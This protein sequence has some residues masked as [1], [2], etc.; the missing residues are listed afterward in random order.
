MVSGL[1][2]AFAVGSSSGETGGGQGSSNT[3]QYLTVAIAFPLVL[4]FFQAIAI[5][6]VAEAAGTS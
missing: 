4:G 3:A 6:P 5:G 2:Y 1:F